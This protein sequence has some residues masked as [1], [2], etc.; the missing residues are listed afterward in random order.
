[1]STDKDVPDNHQCFI[2]SIKGNSLKL[3]SKHWFFSFTQNSYKTCKCIMKKKEFQFLT[4]YSCRHWWIG[5]GVANMHMYIM[6]L[7]CL[8]EIK[9]N[10]RI[11]RKKM[12][13]QMVPGTIFFSSIWF[14]EQY[15]FSSHGSRHHNFSY[16]GS[17]N[18]NNFIYRSGNQ[19]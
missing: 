16:H 4:K 17:G 15:F 11:W 18:Q 13:P 8:I 1:M 6:L 10:V 7:S 5:W 2:T 14:P 9:E 3:W 19:K 12:V